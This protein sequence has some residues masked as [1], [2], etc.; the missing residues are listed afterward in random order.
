MDYAAIIKESVSTPELFAYY[1]FER[2]RAGKVHCVFHEDRNPSMKVYDGSGGYHCFVCNA[3]GDVIDFVQQH[4]HLPFRDAL[5]KINNDFG[6]GLPINS[7]LDYEKRRQMQREAEERRRKRDAVK[8]EHERLC[9][10]Y[11]VAFDEWLRLCR[12]KEEYAP[13]T[14][15]EPFNPTF[16]EALTR[17]ASAE[18]A[19]ECAKTRLYLFEKNMR[20]RR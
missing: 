2:N 7:H 15:S 9:E 13:R 16:V 20:E 19:L 3:N 12:Q 17:M 5:G 11:D 10:A 1:G 4:F 14:P 6:L 18:E 8:K